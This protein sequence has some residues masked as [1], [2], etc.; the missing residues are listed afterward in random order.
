MVIAVGMEYQ[1]VVMEVL[2]ATLEAHLVM[3]DRLVIME[4]QVVATVV[5]EQSI[6]DRLFQ[7]F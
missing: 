4:D 1:L 3:E 5:Q 2:I 6:M 7:K